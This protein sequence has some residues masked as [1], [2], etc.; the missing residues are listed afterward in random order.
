MRAAIRRR[1]IMPVPGLPMMNQE[2]G[3]EDKMIHNPQ[4]RR[5]LA[6]LLTVLGGMAIFLVPEDIWIGAFLLA[7]GVA[8]EVA[9]RLMQRG[10][11]G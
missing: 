1:M 3:K 7:L 4:A 8:L 11:E 2:T 9:G 10:R 5:A 6:L